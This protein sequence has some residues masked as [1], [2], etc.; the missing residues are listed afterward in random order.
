VAYRHD[1]L[2]DHFVE[3]FFRL[4]LEPLFLVVYD[5]NITIFDRF[6]KESKKNKSKISRN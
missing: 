6:S 2:L 5:I 1:H 4:H 3:F